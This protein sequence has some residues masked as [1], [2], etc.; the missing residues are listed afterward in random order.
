M[1]AKNH[2]NKR[3]TL[4]EKSIGTA[5]QAPGHPNDPVS[6]F[7]GNHYAFKNG[8]HD[9]GMMDIKTGIHQHLASFASERTGLKLDQEAMAVAFPNETVVL[10][11]WRSWKGDLVLK[12]VDI[13]PL[14]GKPGA[15]HSMELKDVFHRVNMH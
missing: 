8:R 6:M 5:A 1:P 11:F 4:K 2:K 12:Q 13:S 7:F 15:I 9:L 14:N 10:A 3:L